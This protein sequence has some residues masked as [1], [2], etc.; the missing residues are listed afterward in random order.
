M[1]LDELPRLLRAG[2]DGGPDVQSRAAGQPAWPG[3]EDRAALTFMMW[4]NAPDHGRLPHLVGLFEQMYLLQ[5]LE[6][7]ARNRPGRVVKT[8]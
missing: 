2:A 7:W 4:G 3:W 6:V 1:K 8:P 5:R